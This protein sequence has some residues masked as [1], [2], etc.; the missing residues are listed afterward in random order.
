[1]ISPT[2]LVLLGTLG[3]AQ[4]TDYFF[5]FVGGNTVTNGQRLRFNVSFPII[6]PGVT[7]A[8]YNPDDHFARIYNNASVSP[9]T[10]YVVPTNPHPPPVPGYYGLS[11]AEGVPDAYRLIQ[12]YHPSDEGTPFLY[13]DWKLEPSCSGNGTVLLR[14]GKDPHGEKRWIA[15]K[16]T[17]NSGVE[18]WVPWYVKPTAAN[19]AN[20]TAWDYD[21]ADLELVVTTG[22]VA[23]N[24]PGGVIE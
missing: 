1:M 4:A 11:G 21:I 12:S 3:T 24:A 14:Y 13:Q 8:P 19:I 2:L 20:L 7:P 6:S 17:T 18:K 10:L 15:V 23:S 5:R 9:S 16:E 22:Q